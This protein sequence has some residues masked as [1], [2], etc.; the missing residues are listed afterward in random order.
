ML[1]SLR[2]FLEFSEFSSGDISHCLAF[3]S[4]TFGSENVLDK[5]LGHSSYK[6]NS[7]SLSCHTGKKIF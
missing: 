7:Y 2:G 1:A 5:T 6:K 4:S 3:C